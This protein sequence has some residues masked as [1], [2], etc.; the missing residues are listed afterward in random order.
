MRQALL[1]YRNFRGCQGFSAPVVWDMFFYCGR[2]AALRSVPLFRLRASSFL[3]AQKG[4]KDALKNPRFLRISFHGDLGAG[5]R[6]RAGLGP[7]PTE[8]R[9][10]VGPV[11]AP[12]KR[13]LSPPKAVTGSFSSPAGAVEKN[14]RKETLRHGFAVPPPFS[15]EVLRGVAR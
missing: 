14:R 13:G 2:S 11:Q 3:R 12:L 10:G 8:G 15:R 6:M 4:T 5:Y 1:L 7:A 9:A